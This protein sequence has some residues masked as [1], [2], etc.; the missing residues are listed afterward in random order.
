[1]PPLAKPAP[2]P[3]MFCSAIPTFTK[4]S[5][6]LAP[7]FVSMVEETESFTTT[8]MRESC[9][10]I[11]SSDWEYASRQSNSFAGA[12]PGAVDWSGAVALIDSHLLPVPQL[13]Q[14][15]A[16]ASAHHDAMR[17]CSRQKRLPCP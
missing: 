13:L 10:A 2:T 11:A 12:V 1:M 9:S 6:N 15:A 7:K 17:A 16:P 4:R 3:T 8:H 5:G 14:Q